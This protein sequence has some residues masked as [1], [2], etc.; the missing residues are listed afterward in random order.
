MVIKVKRNGQWVEVVSSGSSGGTVEIDA[1]LTQQGKAADAKAVGDAINDLPINVDE[2]GYTDIRGMP[3]MT[4]WIVSE[5]AN[6]I[7]LVCNMENGEAHTHVLSFDDNGYPIRIT[8]DGINIDGTW[9]IN[10]EV[11]DE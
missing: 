8:V 9:A 5:A 2:N 3:H 11:S 4:N 7:T 6:S 10:E 1:T